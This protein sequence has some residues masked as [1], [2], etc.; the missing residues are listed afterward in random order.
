MQTIG[1]QLMFDQFGPICAQVVVGRCPPG[2]LLANVFANFAARSEAELKV[3]PWSSAISG[4]A[5]GSM[6]S[7]DMGAEPGTRSAEHA[8][9]TAQMRLCHLW[10]GFSRAL[11]FGEVWPASSEEVP[12]RHRARSPTEGSANIRPGSAPRSSELANV[13]AACTS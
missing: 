2:M 7:Q 4:A 8:G 10:M 12:R 9:D 3:F 5:P 11:P 1:P 6:A 13:G